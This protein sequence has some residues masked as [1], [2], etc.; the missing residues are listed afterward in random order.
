M[1]VLLV[2]PPAVAGGAALGCA[3]ALRRL[4][5]DARVEVVGPLE[6][7]GDWSIRTTIRNLWT[8]ARARTCMPIARCATIP[9]AMPSFLQAS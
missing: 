7:P 9:A 6:V 4:G 5:P 2:E 3:D 1:R 8:T